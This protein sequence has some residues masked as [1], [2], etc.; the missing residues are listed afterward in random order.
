MGGLNTFH[1]VYCRVSTFISNIAS[2]CNDGNV[3]S[4]HIS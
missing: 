4:F 3:T 1:P 2:T